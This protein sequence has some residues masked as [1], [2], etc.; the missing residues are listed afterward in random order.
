MK[1]KANTYLKS[2]NNNLK[3]FR[4]ELVFTPLLVALPV[5]VSIFL[6][7]DWYSR[8]VSTGNTIYNGELILAVI[9]LIGNFMFDIP[10]IR[11]LVRFKK[12]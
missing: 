11:S 9:I 4:S 7:Y 8:G 10:F 12:K 3:I 6:I 5:L 2:Y 1:K